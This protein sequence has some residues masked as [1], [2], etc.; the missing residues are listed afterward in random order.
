MPEHLGYLQ[1]SSKSRFNYW[2]NYTVAQAQRPIS[3]LTT[4]NKHTLLES[5]RSDA[6]SSLDPAR[7]GCRRTVFCSIPSPLWRSGQLAQ[8]HKLLSNMRGRTLELKWL[9]RNTTEAKVLVNECHSAFWHQTALFVITE[10][11]VSVRSGL[12]SEEQQSI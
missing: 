11:W 9:Q 2:E 7:F 1:Y 4:H 10:L 6:A 12:T 8:G 3:P 5:A